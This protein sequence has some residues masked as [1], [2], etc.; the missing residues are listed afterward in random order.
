PM[1]Q[2]P[3]PRTS[4]I[5]S[6]TLPAL[7]AKLPE[8]ALPSWHSAPPVRRRGSQLFPEPERSGAESSMEVLS[9]QQVSPEP[10]YG[11][12]PLRASRRAL[13]VIGAMVV[14][15]GFI[16]ATVTVMTLN[17]YVQTEAKLYAQAKNE[18]DQGKYASATN[19]YQN[20]VKAFPS[21]ESHSLYQ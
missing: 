11:I 16:I 2:P 10:T 20:L 8:E 14:V 6:K 9:S 5:A 4:K 17:A 7:P 18:Y 15:A 1:E 13:W 3:G 12:A 21:S 19:A